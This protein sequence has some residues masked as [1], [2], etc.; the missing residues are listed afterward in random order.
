MDEVGGDS[1]YEIYVD[2]YFVFNF[3]MNLWVLFL[4]RFLLHSRVKRRWV[5]V[6]SIGA[7]IGEVIVLCLPI[8]NG[9]LK[10][11]LGFG[12]ITALTCYYLFRPKSKQ[13]FCKILMTCYTSAILLGGILLGIENIVRRENL[14]ISLLGILVVLLVW[15]IIVTYKKWNQKRE[16]YDIEIYFSE[17]DRCMVC[18]LV[19]S[20]NGL[21]DPISKMPVSV[22][23]ATVVERFKNCLKEEN[24]RI[25]P[26]HSIGKDKGIMDA[27]F[28]EKMVI[29][30]EGENVIIQNPIIALTKEVISV[31]G[32]YQMIL[33]PKILN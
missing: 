7:A 6:D 26:F 23:E 29:K 19:D 17:D 28:I 32:R 9:Y 2:M 30:R 10:I 20:G 14:P 18:A 16:Y 1:I 25:I 13:Y 27:Y 33:H 24:F 31:N 5:V 11:I 22:L 21:M 8:G 3:W 15:G 4:C 12:G